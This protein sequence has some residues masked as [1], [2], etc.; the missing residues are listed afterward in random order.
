MEN[1][2]VFLNLP[3]NRVEISNKGI[4]FY[5]TTIITIDND[6]RW[7][8]SDNFIQTDLPDN[9][10]NRWHQPN[11]KMLKDGAVINVKMKKNEQ[12]ITEND[13]YG[14]ELWETDSFFL[15]KSWKVHYNIEEI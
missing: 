6:Y 1:I 8:I 7:V 14:E 3:E 12:K 4:P 11:K 10:Y 5:C 2:E 9:S 15:D 13:P